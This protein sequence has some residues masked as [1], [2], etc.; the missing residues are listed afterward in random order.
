MY[1]KIERRQEQNNFL[2]LLGKKAKIYLVVL[3]WMLFFVKQSE[4]LIIW[5]N[6]TSEDVTLPD[7]GQLK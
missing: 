5:T 3:D 4:Y 6:K 2:S 7:I 1:E